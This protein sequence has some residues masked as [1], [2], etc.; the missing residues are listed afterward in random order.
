MEPL[1]C[2]C[3]ASQRQLRVLRQGFAEHGEDWLRKELDKHSVR[4]LRGVA[5][6]AGVPRNEG[7]AQRSKKDL[8]AALCRCIA[9]EEAS[10]GIDLV[11]HVSC[12][13]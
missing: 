6:A 7:G 10:R 13:S 8:L 5:A 11:D 2:E 12:R 3:M 1:R 4:E 9:E